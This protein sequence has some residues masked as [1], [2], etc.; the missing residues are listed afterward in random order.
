M[1]DILIKSGGARPL[2]TPI[3]HSGSRYASLL[4]GFDGTST[5]EVLFYSAS[6][7]FKILSV[8]MLT[9]SIL[10]SGAAIGLTGDVLF[11]SSTT[12]V[13]RFKF[14]STDIQFIDSTQFGDSATRNPAILVC[15]DGGII[16]MGSQ[17]M[18]QYEIV[19]AQLVGSSWNKFR[20][21]L[22]DAG[23][24]G[25][26]SHNLAIAQHPAD[27]RIHVYMSHDGS[28]SILQARFDKT[29][30]GL[31]LLQCNAEFLSD[32]K[33]NGIHINGLLSPNGENP[34][35]AVIPNKTIG[36]LIIA[37]TNYT[38]QTVSFQISSPVTLAAIGVD[39]VPRLLAS[40]T[41]L[42][43]HNDVGISLALVLGGIAL[44]YPPIFNGTNGQDRIHQVVRADNGI[45]S[46]PVK[47]VDTKRNAYSWHP[48][49]HYLI[50]SPDGSTR[51]LLPDAAVIPQTPS[52]ALIAETQIVR[53]TLTS[54][55]AIKVCDQL[56]KTQKLLV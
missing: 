42:M 55:D 16:V 44:N 43:P 53:S 24:S 29:P 11:I 41:E 13:F 51:L 23:N 8:P 2:W 37:Y 46:P 39:N 7:E 28:H 25:V 26:A 18:P 1:R 54:P 31:N 5:A 12:S 50:W 40:T 9:N 49:G 6:G 10:S 17:Q 20:I 21:R 14:S 19:G 35:I 4:L 48:D 32:P 22:A 52:Q 34:N 56:L 3:G 15:D 30:I 33:V 27:G 45:V 36:Q 47:I 38:G